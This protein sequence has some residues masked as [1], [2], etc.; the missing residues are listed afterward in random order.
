[1]HIIIDGIVIS[2]N[3]EVD[4]VYLLVIYMVKKVGNYII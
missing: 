3:Q 2:L 4:G 1:M